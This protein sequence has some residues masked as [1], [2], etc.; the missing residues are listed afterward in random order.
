[1]T[2]SISFLVISLFNWSISSWFS[3][4]ELYVSRKLSISSRLSICWH[5]IVHG[6]L[7]F[8]FFL[9]FSILWDFSFL[10]SYFFLF[11]SFSP[12]LG[13]SGQ[14]FVYFVYPFKEPALGFIYFFP[15]S[16][17]S[18][19]YWFPVLYLIFFPSNFGF[20]LFFFS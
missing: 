8:I 9:Y 2:Y 3:F 12:L 14:R 13:D 7:L 4:G 16:F 1:M 18:L 5:I 11:S 19:F 10:V 6:I 17:E 15:L 20:C